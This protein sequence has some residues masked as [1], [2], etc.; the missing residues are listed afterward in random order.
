MIAALEE[1]QTEFNNGQSGNTRISLADLI[2]LGGAAAIEQAAQAGGYD[3]DVPFNPG[4]TDATQAQTDVN[5]VAVLEP[6]YDGFRNYVSSTSLGE[7][8]QLLIE[9]ADML[10]LTAPEMTVL[11]G[12]LRALNANTGG[13]QH[14]VF[15]S[16]PGTLS[17]DFFVNLLDLS[18][19]WNRSA[20][21]EGV[22]I[23]RDQNSGDVRW[24]AT[25]ADLVFGSNSELRAIAEQY[26]FNDS[27]EQFVNDF[28]AAWTKVMNLDRFDLNNTRSSRNQRFAGLN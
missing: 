18:T 25:E 12:G 24:T 16:R 10:N 9:R 22:L 23:G 6:T 13:S 15:T 5:S 4:R 21:T 7:P 20:D 8:A 2:V 14:G 11:V 26:A 28:I 1:I 27:K 19:Q 3:V 17:N